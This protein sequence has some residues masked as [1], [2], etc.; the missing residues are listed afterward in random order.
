MWLKDPED[1]KLSVQCVEK[2][3]LLIVNINSN[4][5]TQHTMTPCVKELCQTLPVVPEGE[6]G[7]L[8]CC[9]LPLV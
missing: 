9:E 4:Q 3:R 5:H 6:W 2:T 7:V 8:F 1:M